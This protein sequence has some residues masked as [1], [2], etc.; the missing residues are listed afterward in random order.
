M[1]N[2]RPSPVRP[3]RSPAGA[4]VTPDAFLPPALAAPPPALTLS[5]RIAADRQRALRGEGHAHGALGRLR[6]ADE[7]ERLSGQYRDLIAALRAVAPLTPRQAQRVSHACHALARA[8]AAVA[9]ALAAAE[10]CLDAPS[11]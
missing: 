3:K 6:E 4:S 11:P 5:E 10:E 9:R 2:N 8:E 7:Y 1:R